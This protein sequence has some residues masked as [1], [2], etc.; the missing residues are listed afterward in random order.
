VANIYRCHTILCDYNH[1][2]WVDFLKKNLE[3]GLDS[4]IEN[5]ERCKMCLYMRIKY[6][7]LY[8]KDRGYDMVSSTFLTN[9]YKD[10]DFVRTTLNDLT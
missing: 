6:S 10:T 4:Y 8:A 2:E 7:F 5:G 3:L 1:D 9:L